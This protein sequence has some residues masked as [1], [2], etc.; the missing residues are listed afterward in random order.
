LTVGIVYKFYDDFKQQNLLDMYP[1]VQK[2][3]EG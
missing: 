1:G 2:F 3:L